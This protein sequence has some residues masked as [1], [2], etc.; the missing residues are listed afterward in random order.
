M[1]TQGTPKD[2]A[3]AVVNALSEVFPDRAWTEASPEVTT[4]LEHVR[5]RLAQ[6]FSYQTFQSAMGNVE[7]ESVVMNLWNKLFPNKKREAA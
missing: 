5:D 1:K 4:V 2:L 3:G 7:A 6:D